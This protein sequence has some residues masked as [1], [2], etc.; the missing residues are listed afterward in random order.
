MAAKFGEDLLNE[1]SKRAPSAFPARIPL[2]PTGQEFYSHG[3]ELRDYFAGAA[4]TGMMAN[5]AV[6][7]NDKDYSDEAYK[8]ADAMME[9][10]KVKDQKKEGS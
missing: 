4:L 7:M 8:T 3:M 10:R 5:S 2:G 9:A 1:L 6:A